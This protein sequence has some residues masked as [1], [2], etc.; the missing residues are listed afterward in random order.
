MDPPTMDP[1]ATDPLEPRTLRAVL[2]R[3]ATGV[4]VVTAASPGG[5]VGMTVNSFSSVSLDPPLVLFCVNRRSRLHPAFAEAEAFAVHMLG[6]G[7][8]DISQRFATP[9]FDRF[10][11][12]RPRE[13]LRG[14]P[15]LDG[16]LAV[17]ECATEQIVA[18]GDHDIVI[19][20]VVMVEAAP[21]AA[22]DPLLYY[23][24]AY[25]SIESQSG[26]WAQLA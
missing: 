10:G 12:I 23:G 21:G 2:G 18:A 1:P 11:E 6:E 5:P 8:R 16:T 19:G 25:R 22:E 13:G 20:R 3:F 14:T 4:A 7:Q 17:I 15:L 26:W 9:G 24:G